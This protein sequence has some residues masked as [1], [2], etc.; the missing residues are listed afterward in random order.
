MGKKPRHK[1]YVDMP[2]AVNEV[3]DEVNLVLNEREKDKYFQSIILMYSFIENLL[4]WLVFVKS[5]WLKSDK[6]LMENEWMK[7]RKSCSDLRFAKASS[8]SLEL[9]VINRKLYRRI[10]KIRDERNDIIHQFWIYTHWG[11]LLVLRKKLEKLANV[12]NR[13][14]GI[15]NDLT[16]EIGVE[17]VYEI[18]LWEDR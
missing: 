2:Q 11:N 10:D 9:R 16:Q 5:L 8:K 7:L 1:Q 4:K 15:F 14:V 6:E 3:A 12:S 17:E 13:L 18:L